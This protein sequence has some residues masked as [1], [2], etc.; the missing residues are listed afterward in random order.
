MDTSQAEWESAL[1]TSVVSNK[2][3]K[4]AIRKKVTPDHFSD[5]LHKNLWSWLMKWF[6]NPAYGDTPSWEATMAAFPNFEPMAVDD[7]TASLADR[8]RSY[9]LHSDLTEALMDVAAIT[10]GSSLDG[11]EALKEHTARLIS[12]HQEDESVSVSAMASTLRDEYALMKTGEQV[13][14]GKAYPWPCMNQATLG[15][16]KGQL[17]VYYARPKSLKAQPLSAQVLTPRGFVRMGALSVGDTI[18]GSDGKPIKVVG[19]YPQGRKPVFRVTMSDGV[20]TR[21]C[22]DHLWY[23]TTY[24]ESRRGAPGRARP[25]SEIRRSLRNAEGRAIHR[26][27]VVAPVEYEPTTEPL[28][29]DPYLLGVLL[30]DGSITRNDLT[31]CNPE[32]DLLQRALSRLPEGDT[33]SYRRTEDRAQAVAIGGRGR[34][35]T[36][37]TVLESLGLLGLRSHE[38]FIPPAYLLASVGH[39][40]ELLRGL[41]DTDG[42][43]VSN[44]IHYSTASSALAANVAELARSLG[45]MVVERRPHVPAYTYKGE[46][47]E[48]RLHYTMSIRPAPGLLFVTS[49]K[50]L[51]KLG[52]VR[53]R[54]RTI[55][56][57]EEDGMEECQ[58]IAVDA[59][60]HL[61][62]TDGFIVTHNTWLA[63]ETLRHAHNQGDRVVVFSQE[64][65]DVEIARRWVALQA[66]VD[67]SDF[68][69]GKLGGDDEA[70][71]L[72]TLDEFIEAPPVIIDRLTS[73]GEGAVTELRAKLG[74]YGATAF[75]IDGMYF[76]GEDWRELASV[77][78]GVKRTAR[79][80]GVAALGTTQ[81][82]RSKTG[83]A[84][85]GNDVAYA[86]SFFQDCDLL[87]ALTREPAHRRNR[88][89]LMTIAAVREGTEAAWV[90][91]ADLCKNLGQKAVVRDEES[92]QEWQNEE[93]SD[94]E[95]M[96]APE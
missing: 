10:R 67:Y 45:A 18:I 62:V 63:L 83:G 78:R 73:T 35:S 58:C 53:S 91:H 90:V 34:R 19:V 81:R 68:L 66:N 54:H 50:H 42:T 2:D 69:T 30:G 11:L 59:A 47:R 25:L 56:R 9:K 88:E 52:D 79:E 43:V 57:V 33:W 32:D 6:A 23:T 72:A 7:S 8:V 71:F 64:L 20:S 17:V 16:Q 92:D 12:A 39:R 49:K 84:A 13:L 70:R 74:D 37:A 3:I 21:C 65:S 95:P 61:Y 4:V 14:K 89:V 36:T 75:L 1:I 24:T 46:R 38:K 94:D 51:S 55:E 82:N 44:T 29:L 26:V 48:G 40:L 96:D 60:D 87:V 27:P 5:A 76:L 85:N 93:P 28:P 31:I 15:W 22:D 41:L 77:T 86:D 80:L